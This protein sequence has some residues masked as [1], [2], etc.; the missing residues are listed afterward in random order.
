MGSRSKSLPRSLAR[1]FTVVHP[2]LKLE[3]RLKIQYYGKNG[4]NTWFVCTSVPRE[5]Q[6]ANEKARL[7]PRTLRREHVKL[8]VRIMRQCS[9]CLAEKS[10]KELW[11]NIYNY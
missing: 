11:H 3:R 5:L 4:R 6:S 2:N 7:L 1:S 8:S 9:R 10:F